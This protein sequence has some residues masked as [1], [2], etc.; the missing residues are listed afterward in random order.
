MIIHAIN[1]GIAIKIEYGFIKNNKYPLTNRI[2]KRYKNLNSRKEENKSLL[3][4]KIKIPKQPINMLSFE[5]AELQKTTDGTQNTANAIM[6]LNFIKY[7][8]KTS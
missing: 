4:V 6:C 1:D 8:Q 5:F 3:K 7:E 2:I